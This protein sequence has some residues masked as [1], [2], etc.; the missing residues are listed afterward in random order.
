M[1]F[2]TTTMLSFTHII[3][4][5]FQR[6]FSSLFP[7]R[8]RAALPDRGCE[9]WFAGVQESIV[10]GEVNIFFR[11]KEYQLRYLC[12]CS[13]KNVRLFFK[14]PFNKLHAYIF[15]KHQATECALFI[16]FL[17]LFCFIQNKGGARLPS[18]VSG[19]AA[20]KTNGEALI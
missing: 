17:S 20:V 2:R 3:F 16:M 6:F 7:F 8:F 12:C 13:V 11:R 15:R 5:A 10:K 18:S 19:G 9:L 4:I 14:C 1:L